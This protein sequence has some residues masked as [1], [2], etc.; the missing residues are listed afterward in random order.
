MAGVTRVLIIGAGPAG[1]RAAETC[2]KAGLHPVV[3]DEAK[4]A[5]GQI[6]RRP[7]I[8]T[9]NGAKDR[10]GPEATKAVALHRCFDR[11]VAKGQLTH[12]S[13]ST[14]T[15]IGQN[16]AQILTGGGMQCLRFERLI[17]ATGAGDRLLPIPGWQSAGVYSLGAMQIALK[18]Q[19]VAL[20]RRLVLAGT[21]PLLTL[22]AAQLIT[23]GV[24]VLAVLDTAPMR[25]QLRARGPWLWRA[26]L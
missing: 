6:Y 10:Y 11:M 9:T 13:D 8:E 19:E 5:G 12:L 7:S 22:V 26:Q 3:V 1:I 20:G 2:V 15:S 4:Q 24:D 17:L 16:T 18:T 23:K 25:Q 14:V 21:G